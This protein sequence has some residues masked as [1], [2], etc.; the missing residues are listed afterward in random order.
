MRILITGASGMIGTA[1]AA[2]LREGGHEPIH[3]PRAELEK[4]MV[5]ARHFDD[6]GAVIHLAGESI[7]GRW[8]T[9]KKK[10]IMES[11]VGPTHRLAVAAAAAAAS[12]SRPAFIS[13][14]AVGFYGDR[15][16]EVLDESSGRGSGFLAEVAEAW[17]ASAAPALAAGLRV[18]RLRLGVVLSP[19]GGAMAKMLLPF[20][21]GLGGP[22]G[23]GKQWVSW[24][25]LPDAAALFARAATDSTMTGVYNATA[26][27]V[28]R[29]AE[30]TSAL[31]AAL[32]RPAVIPTPAFALR[33]L[34][35][36][37]AD[38]TLLA[39]THAAPARLISEGHA[40]R[41]PEIGGS[42]RDLLAAG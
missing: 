35:G 33:L 30:F 22:S 8:T 10:A 28:V 25:A 3:L 1:T 38:A 31:A 26:P 7:D 18:V 29:N 41:H 24:I 32:H 23:S 19:K 21:L 4:P 9:A 27:G 15:G 40:F 42:F 2:M 5:H 12:P 17:E 37:V 20:R 39:S 14:S 6:V 16:D 36:E 13:A 34:F 11:R